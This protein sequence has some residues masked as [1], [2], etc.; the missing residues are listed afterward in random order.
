MLSAAG[1]ALF[2]KRVAAAFAAPADPADPA[3][4]ALA[5]SPLSIGCALAMLRAAAAPGGDALR[6]LDAL[7]AFDKRPE[8]EVQAAFKALSAEGVPGLHLANSI[9]ANAAVRPEFAE[10]LCCLFSAEVR[11]LAGKDAINCYINDK[12]HGLIPSLLAQD[13]DSTVLL[14]VLAIQF[15]RSSFYC[16]YRNKI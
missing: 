16:S 15:D 7:L 2:R 5:V 12:T 6:E 13:P 3:A 14:N 4:G 9:W 10:E 8:A 11:P 1:L